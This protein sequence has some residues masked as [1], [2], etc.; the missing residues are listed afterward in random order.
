MQELKIVGD[1]TICPVIALVRNNQLLI[2]LRHYT[3][4]KWKEIS[5]WTLPGGRCDKGELLGETLKREVREEIGINDIKISQFLGI[6]PGAKN[7][8][9][10]YTFLGETNENPKLIEPEKFSEWKW[11]DINQIP[12]NFININ[13][14]KL[15]KEKILEK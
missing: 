13:S 1:Q 15:I 5:V 12:S 7:G 3:P 4:D 10:V 11:C 9:V 8:D 14:L 6:V 2:G